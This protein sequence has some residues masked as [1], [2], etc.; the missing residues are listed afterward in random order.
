MDATRHLKKPFYQ[1]R[2]KGHQGAMELYHH[3]TVY[4]RGRMSGHMLDWSQQPEPFKRYRHR[5]P[6]ALPEPRPP[7]E[8]LWRLAL[9]WPPPSAPRPGPPDAA[10]LAAVLLMAAGVTSAGGH[11]LRAPASA[12]ALYPAELYSAA[13][14]VEGIEDGLYHFAPGVPGLH[15]LWPGPLAAA[16]ARCLDAGPSA[17]TFFISGMFWRSVWKY[18]DRAYR[19]CLLDA[20]HMLANLE[21]ACAACGAAPNAHVDFLDASAT[22]FLGLAKEEEA[23][24]CVLAAGS[25]PEDPGPEDLQLPPFDLQSVP[26]SARVGRDPAIA[27]AHEAG[28]LD[29]H[30]GPRRFLSLK[31][32]PELIGLD[33]PRPPAADLLDVVRRRRSRR[34]FLPASLDDGQVSALLAAALPA[35]GPVLAS[36]LLAPGGELEGGRYL[37]LPGAHV[38]APQSV[39]GDARGELAGACLGQAWLGRAAMVLVLWQDLARLTEA[40]G[41]RAYRHA[42]LAAGRAGQRLYLAATA[43]GLGCCGVG[44]FYDD[45][46]ARHAGLPPGGDV[47]YLLACGPVTNPV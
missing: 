17:L 46:A 15:Q 47:L 28:R 4:E 9:E 16:A 36:V 34:A 37:Y 6:L 43:L 40:V 24:L 22:V 29:A 13:C 27:A 18:R 11:M 39:P 32:P 7:R 30:P 19:Y 2:P 12:G 41:P 14:G 23:P 42:M 38:L 20:G 26:P 10:D 35:P 8:D 3:Q 1:Q 5:E 44:A 45:E 25:E 33:P 21:L 31:P